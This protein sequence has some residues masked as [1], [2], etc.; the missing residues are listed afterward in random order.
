MQSILVAAFIIACAIAAMGFYLRSHPP[1][2]PD[3]AV[4]RLRFGINVGMATS[5][6]ILLLLALMLF[7]PPVLG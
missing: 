3:E 1:D 5:A 6:G 4:R 2:E 7:H